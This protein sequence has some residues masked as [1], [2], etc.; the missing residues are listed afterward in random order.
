MSPESPPHAASGPPVSLPRRSP[1]STRAGM[2]T[3]RLT[4][5][6]GPG[7]DTDLL[8]AA[9]PTA[10][11]P[12]SE[13]DYRQQIGRRVRLARIGL[14]LSQDETAHRAPDVTRNFVSAIERG[15]QGLDTWRLRQLADALDVSLAWLLG[16]S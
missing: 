7:I 12:T 2:F 14:G 4:S 1:S 11:S 6:V 5:A 3:S 15:A 9:A 16:P 13:A 10:T 8:T